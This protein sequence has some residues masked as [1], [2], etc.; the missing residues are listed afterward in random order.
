[1][2]PALVSTTGVSAAHARCIASGISMAAPAALVERTRNVRRSTFAIR[3]LDPKPRALMFVFSRSILLASYSDVARPSIRDV[4][5]AAV[6]V[7][8]KRRP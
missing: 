8:P 1:M 5:C 6:G 3:P 2:F 4:R 7:G